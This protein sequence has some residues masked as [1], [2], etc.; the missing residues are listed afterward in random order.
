M[1]N[2]GFMP[3]TGGLQQVSGLP[4]AVAVVNNGDR[5]TALLLTMFNACS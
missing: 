2:R 4:P 3:L 1:I 5:R